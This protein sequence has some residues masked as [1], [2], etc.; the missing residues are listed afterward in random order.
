MPGSRVGTSAVSISHADAAA[1]RHLGGRA[2]EA[3]GAHVLDRDDVAASDQLEARL[4]EELLG[5]GIAD[6]DLGPPRLALLAQFL[7]GEARPVDAVA[8]G[9]GAHDEQHV[10]HAVRPRRVIRSVSRRRPTHIALTSGLP[11]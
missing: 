8:P 1:R 10:A 9:A 5:E 7:R 4:E 3:G 2:G 11:V 6:L